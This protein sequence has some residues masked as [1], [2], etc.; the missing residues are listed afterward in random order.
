MPKLY[1]PLK[2][3]K[4]ILFLFNILKFVNVGVVEQ[5][6]TDRGEMI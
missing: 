2:K 1:A 4:K 5:Q 6:L 3:K